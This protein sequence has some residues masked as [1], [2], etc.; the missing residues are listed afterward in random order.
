MI[1]IALFILYF[2]VESELK[3]NI[4][5]IAD[6]TNKPNKMLTYVGY[7]RTPWEAF[8]HYDGQWWRTK[9]KLICSASCSFW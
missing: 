2:L 4:F 1:V 6:I 7:S 5:A 9:H 3:V 8:V